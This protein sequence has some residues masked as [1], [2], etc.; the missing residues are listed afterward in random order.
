MA[1]L[2][3][4]EKE[5]IGNINMMHLQNDVNTELKQVKFKIKHQINFYS[6]YSEWMTLNTQLCTFAFTWALCEDLKKCL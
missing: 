1:E 3:K 2:E 5:K 4:R 6:C